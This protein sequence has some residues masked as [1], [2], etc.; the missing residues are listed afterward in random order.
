MDFL[1][2]HEGGKKRMLFCME[3]ANRHHANDMRKEA[4]KQWNLYL[5]IRSIN[6]RRNMHKIKRRPSCAM[7]CFTIPWS[8]ASAYRKI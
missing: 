1:K 8:N 4:I 7:L 6:G 5:R 3:W 2:S